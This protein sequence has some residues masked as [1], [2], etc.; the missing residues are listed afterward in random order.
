M[1][2]GADTLWLR[3]KSKISVQKNEWMKLWICS[4]NRTMSIFREIHFPFGYSKTVKYSCSIIYWLVTQLQSMRVYSSRYVDIS[5]VEWRTLVITS[6][7]LEQNMDIASWRGLNGSMFQINSA[8]R[9]AVIVSTEECCVWALIVCSTDGW[10]S[11]RIK[12]V[13]NQLVICF[14]A[15]LH[16]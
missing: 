9:F 7:T 6:N 10:E 16:N 12:L 3:N 15:Q 4:K 5:C 11:V 1:L 13:N 2:T 8:W 14:L